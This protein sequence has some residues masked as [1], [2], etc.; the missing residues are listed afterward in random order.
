MRRNNRQFNL[1]FI[2][3]ISVLVGLIILVVGIYLHAKKALAEYDAKDE[4]LIVE[5]LGES[6]EDIFPGA[7]ISRIWDDNG[8]GNTTGQL[9]IHYDYGTDKEREEQL[10]LSEVENRSIEEL[11]DLKKYSLPYAD[12]DGMSYVSN[13]ISEYEDIFVRSLRSYDNED[14]WV[15]CPKSEE[16]THEVDVFFL[17]PTSIQGEEGIYNINLEDYREGGDR[18]EFAG[19][20]NI[21]KGIYDDMADFYAPYYEQ[22]SLNGYYDTVP[23]QVENMYLNRA[24]EDVS[25]AF[26]YYLDNYNNGRKIVLAGFS[27]GSDMMKRLLKQYD[28]GDKL[29]AAYMIGWNITDEDLAECSRLKMAEGELDL[30]VIISFCSEADYAETSVIVP[31]T[32]NGINPLNWKT[33]G[34]KADKN[35]NLGSCFMAFDGSILEDHQKLCGAY[36]DEK[37]GTLKVT[38]VSA[39]K[40]VPDLGFLKPGDYHVYDYMFFYRNLEQNVQYRIMTSLGYSKEQME[41]EYIKTAAKNVIDPEKER[42]KKQEQ[43]KKQSVQTPSVPVQEMPTV[44]ETPVVPAPEVTAPSQEIQPQVPEIIVPENTMPEVILPVEPVQ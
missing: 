40:F 25:S 22:M 21:Q 39:D 16:K 23:D 32:T 29:I 24:Y 27:Q 18:Y 38:D 43:E 7:G 33:D 1:L 15:Y 42:E 13:E 17:C 5:D 6:V 44:P 41:K 10:D 14:M 34:T 12:P 2:V 11:V 4:K 3:L 36:L 9:T 28:L 30:G 37:R 8:T 19:T 20:V 35:S 31:E 26:S